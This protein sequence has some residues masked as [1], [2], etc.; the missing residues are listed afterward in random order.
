[1]GGEGG[2]GFEVNM[3]FGMRGVYLTLLSCYLPENDGTARE[4][5]VLQHAIIPCAVAE[6]EYLWQRRES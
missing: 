4:C 3:L 6:K 5:V 2:G 1:M